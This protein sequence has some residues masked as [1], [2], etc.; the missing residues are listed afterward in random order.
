MSE[1]GARTLWALGQCHFQDRT[2]HPRP[3]PVC[4]EH[5]L[6]LRNVGFEGDGAEL[7]QLLVVEQ[8][9]LVPEESNRR[10][11]MGVSPQDVGVREKV[12]NLPL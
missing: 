8:Q 11:E 10:T 9:V 3:S 5:R 12:S 2:G 6:H 7:I 4:V 1:G